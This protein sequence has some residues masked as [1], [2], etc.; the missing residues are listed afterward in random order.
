MHCLVKM[1]QNTAGD[2]SPDTE[3]PQLFPNV[4]KIPRYFHFVYFACVLYYLG[5]WAAVSVVSTLSFHNIT[6]DLQ[7]VM[8]CVYERNKM[9]MM[10]F[11]IQVVTMH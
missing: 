2:H 5:L 8:L 10:I 6:C 7:N 11:S 9:M 4:C 3:I 1:P